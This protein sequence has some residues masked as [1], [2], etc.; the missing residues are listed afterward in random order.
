[1]SYSS[2]NIIFRQNLC[3]FCLALLCCFIASCEGG[4][5]NT[6]LSISGFSV[7]GTDGKASGKDNP[8]RIEPTQSGGRFIA[9][10]DA[11]IPPS[12]KTGRVE[13]NSFDLIL[14]PRT[15]A[16]DRRNAILMTL[17]CNGSGCQSGE[18]SCIYDRSNAITCS[19]SS[20]GAHRKDIGSYL[21]STGGIPNR[22][23]ILIKI[24]SNRCGVDELPQPISCE[25]AAA[26][27]V[28]Y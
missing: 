15:D 20:A 12:A 14:S 5:S 13:G 21:S 1:M 6:E 28:L 25:T 22:S 19:H 16:A 3:I 11:A 2:V 9:R 17:C 23:N 7:V 18:F 24:C 27:V 26:G 10:Y 8:A 4:G